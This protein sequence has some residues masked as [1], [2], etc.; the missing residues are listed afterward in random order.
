MILAFRKNGFICKAGKNKAKL[1]SEDRNVYFQNIWNPRKGKVGNLSHESDCEQ[2]NIWVFA[3]QASWLKLFKCHQPHKL[4]IIFFLPPIWLSSKCFRYAPCELKWHMNY[5][6]G[7]TSNLSFQEGAC[8]WNHITGTCT[9]AGSTKG[10]LPLPGQS[11]KNKNKW[12]E[13]FLEMS[14]SV[15]THS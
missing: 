10:V 2:V 15:V 5:V 12:E 3:S 8:Q 6:T 1:K 7:D 9:L 11:G 13:L 14:F 4:H